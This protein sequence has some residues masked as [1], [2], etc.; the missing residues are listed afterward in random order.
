[1]DEPLVLARE[2]W[3]FFYFDKHYGLANDTFATMQR[4]CGMLG[5]RVEEP[6]WVE[7]PFN[8]GPKEMVTAIEQS[9]DPKQH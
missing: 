9:V 4:A 8:L 7:V 2:R 1:M 5:M 6:Q 3:L